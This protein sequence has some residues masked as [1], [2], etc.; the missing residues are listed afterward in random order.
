MK[1]LWPWVLAGAAL[2]A[3]V[4]ALFQGEVQAARD[5]SAHVFPE[6]YFLVARWS[7]G[8]VPLW[9]PHA[10]LGQP[11]L[12]LLYTQVF[13]APRLLS[14]WLFG[15]VLGPNVLHLFHAG[16]AFAGLY[17]AS[18]SFGLQRAF[19]F[20]GAAPFA[21]SPFF[22]ELAQNFSFASTAAWAGWTAWAA[23]GL[24]RTPSLS[25][26]AWL[27]AALGFAF[28]A[29]SPE[30]WLTQLLLVVF[31]LLPSLR[32]IGWGVLA[33][34]WAGALS[35][36]VALP[37]LELSRTWMQAGQA[38][39]GATQWSVSWAQLLSILVA[40]ADL[41]RAG[42]YWGGPDQHFLFTLFTGG[43]GTLLALLGAQVKRARPVLLFV[44]LALVLCLGQHFFLSKWL[45][46]VPPFSLF[47]YS[48]KYA[49]GLLFGASLLAGFGARRLTALSKQSRGFWSPHLMALLGL[50]LG[51]VLASRW[52]WV[53]DGYRDHAPWLLATTLALMVLRAR[54]GLLAIAVAAELTFAPVTKWDRLPAHELSQPS[55]LAPLLRGAGR[56]SIRVDLDD[57]DPQACGPW[58]RD[59]HDLLLDGRDRLAGLRFVEEDLRATG[60]YGFRDPW[61]LGRAFSQGAGAFAVAGV[62]TFVRETWAPVPNGALTVSTTPIDDVWIWK[63]APAFSRGF[64][65]SQ[66]RVA[67][68]EAA[69]AALGAS[70]SELAKTV[71]VDRGEPVNGTSCV[72]E[73]TTIERQ[74]EEV[75]Q[76]LTACSEGAVVLG[77]AWY[78]GWAVEVDGAP[79]EALRAWGFLRAVRVSAGPHRIVWRYQPLSFRLGATITAVGLLA[80]AAV[81]LRRRPA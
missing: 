45:L 40:D 20:I 39:S 16:W 2:G 8:Q 68:D 76:Q 7:E 42:G 31:L 66:V 43:L 19:A 14:G 79:A 4:S 67:D 30:L 1:R 75:E 77:D 46:A 55:Q 73:V 63:G 3:S 54:P 48:A 51:L 53:R 41:P 71:I 35:A 80:L 61:R 12:A 64:F 69:F 70:R 28:H 60:G 57:H 47:R 10:R 72:S 26:A 24:R 49:V 32:A 58:D 25:R 6:T 29:G 11:F 52:S 33:V 74:P 9:L 44:T 37:A 50:A 38:L 27:A 23:E 56:L 22:S 21:L 81:V 15:H 5:L 59:D 36:V 62:S 13:Y 65:V 17:F 18:R 34:A 78:P